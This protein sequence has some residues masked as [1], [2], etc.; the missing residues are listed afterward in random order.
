MSR[1]LGCPA[2]AAFA[3]VSALVLEVLVARAVLVVVLVAAIVVEGGG[4]KWWG[5]WKVGWWF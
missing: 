3:L 2:A 1:K 5:G 4:E